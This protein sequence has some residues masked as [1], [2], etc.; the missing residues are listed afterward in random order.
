MAD[1]KLQANLTLSTD[2]DYDCTYSDTFEDVFVSNFVVENLDKFTQIQEGTRTKGLG[3]IETAKAVLIKNTGN[4]CAEILI[5]AQDYKDTSSV[6]AAN[7]VD[8]GGGGATK[9]RSFSMLLPAQRFVFLPNTRMISYSS[10]DDATDGNLI[11]QSAAN[12]PVGAVSI[13]PKSINS[14][15]KYKAIAQIGSGPAYGNGTAVLVNDGDATATSTELTVD[16]HHWLK[17]GD[18]LMME[19]GGVQEIVQIT[20]MQ[21]NTTITIARALDGS[22]AVV[23]ANDTPL[24]YAFHNGYLPFDT[25]KVQTDANGRFKQHGAFFGYARTAD[26]VVDGLVPGSV[27]IGPFYTEGGYLDWG[28]SGITANTETGLAKSTAYRFYLIIDDYEADGLDSTTNEQAINF[29]TDA[30]DTTFAGSANAVLPKIQAVLDEQFY[31][32]SSKLKNKKVSIGLVNGDVRITSHSNHSDTRVGISDVDGTSP[33]SV[34]AFPLV[35]SNIIGVEGQLVS[36]GTDAIMYGPASYL[37]PETISDSTT[38][39]TITNDSAFIF[40]DG[41]GNLLYMGRK[42]GYIDYEK[43]HCE[44]H[45]PSLPNAEFKVHAESHSA[46]SGGSAY[47]NDGYNTIQEIRARSV[48]NQKDA[49]LQVISVG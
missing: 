9:L 44:W 11:Y 21:S 43:G 34:G 2:T 49:K 3:S 26:A 42:V 17:E 8:V 19:V 1:K 5:T 41:N 10:T 14:G 35:A 20:F 33:F 16:D 4:I 29:T 37:A 45:I 23:I 24:I 47:T 6:D 27:S 25:S 48:N 32:T 46:H 7:N 31:T 22:K 28:L 38:G 13:E 40:D 30:S 12:A 15:N 39:K 36:T 18:K